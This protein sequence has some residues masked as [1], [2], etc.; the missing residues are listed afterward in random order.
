MKTNILML[1][2]FMIGSQSF[3]QYFYKTDSVQTIKITFAQSNW[4][5]LM[6]AEKASTENYIMAQSVEINGVLYDSVGVK[7]KGNSTYNASYVKNPLH[8]ELDTY[9][10]QDHEGY[11]DIKLSNGVKDPSFIRE[12][13]SYDIINKYMDAPLSNFANVYINGSLIGFYA[14]SESI[15]KKFVNSR[16]GSKSN[17]F[18]KCNPP[19]GAGPGSTAV[20]SLEYLGT[21]SSNYYDAYEIKSD[22]GWDELIDLCDTLS[23]DVSSIEQILDIDRTIWMLALDNVMVNLDS[24]IGQ[25]A[26]NYYLYRDSY[27]RFLPVIWDLNESFGVFS[28]SGS[29]NLNSTA[30]KQQMSHLLHSTDANF[31]LVSKLL[32]IPSYKRMYLAHYKTILEEN[33]YANGPYISTA[34]TIMNTAD[35]HV[36]A[37]P[38]KFYTYANFI[39]N[40]NTDISGGGGP[41]GGTTPG[42]TNLMNGRY[43]YLMSQSDFTATQPSISAVTASNTNPTIGDMVSI[44]ATITD[45]DVA[46]LRYRT[47]EGAP[48]EKVQM[49][50][51]GNHNDGAAGDDVFGADVTMSS[52]TMQYYIYAENSNIGKFSPVRAEHEFYSI[53]ATGGITTGDIVINEFMAS[54]DFTVTDQDGE[55]DDWIELYNNSSSSIDIGGYGLS[56]DLTDLTLY[57]F[58]AGTTLPGQGYLVVWADK[59][60][61]QNGYHA[62][63]KISS[64]GETIYLSDAN[65]VLIDSVAFGA[66]NTD[67]TYGRYPNGTGN[68]QELVATFGAQNTVDGTDASEY[69]ISD[70]DIKIYP[71]PSHHA[72]TVKCPDHNLQEYTIIVYNMMGQKV[73][74]SLMREEITIP[75]INWTDGMYFINMNEF[76]AKVV[77]SH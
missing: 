30:A 27:G 7:Y 72:F 66:Q 11:T 32:A 8:I 4:D 52:L 60:L 55:Y 48:F 47:Q 2:A 33:F 70:N 41:G 3:A 10:D 18:V 77:I 13:L 49:Y 16:F 15:S 20:P 6:D 31:P 58:P 25:F 1:L 28:M 44:T 37:D 21:D 73:F 65:Q 62:D 12:V 23:N 40:L 9:K 35:A 74:K 14:N 75:T 57:T 50:D 53:T 56:D 19:D 71:N 29:G 61:T 46:Y 67:V 69:I 68:F 64:S 63:F 36:Q 43:S 45:E 59:D 39:A 5:A 26:Q 76:S 38:N 34:T 54:N 42:I 17:T 24:Y 51:D 22:Y